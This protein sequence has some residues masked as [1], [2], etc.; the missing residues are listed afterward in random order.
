MAGFKIFPDRKYF[1][2]IY[3]KKRELLWRWEKNIAGG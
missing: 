1:K 3:F 2:S